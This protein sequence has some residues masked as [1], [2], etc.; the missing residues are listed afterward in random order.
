MQNYASLQETHEPD[1]EGGVLVHVAEPSRARWNHIEDL[2]S[3]FSR[4]YQYHQRHGLYCMLLQEVLELIQFVFIVV[5]T[6]YVFHGINYPVLFKDVP[7]PT[8]ATKV[9]LHDVVLPFGECVSNFSALTWIALIIAIIVWILKL[10]RGVYHFFHFWDIKQFYNTALKI[11]DGELDNL[12]WHEVQTKVRTVQIEQQMCIHKR[13]LSELDIYHRILRQQNYL[14]AM[15][16]K[17]L[18]PPRLKVPFLGEVVYWTSGL[19]LNIQLLFF[20]SPWSPFEHPWHLREE[21]K[22]PNLR[23]DLANQFGKHILWLALANL[24]FAP[25]IF[26]WQILYAFFSYAAIIRKEPSL[27]AVRRWSL[28]GRLYLRHFNELEHE[29]QARLT[30]AHRP[31]SKYLAA[32]TSPL[33]TIISENIGFYATSF[34]AVLV[35]LSIID[36]DVLTV[37]HVLTIMT[38]LTVA[39]AVL[40]SLAPDETTSSDLE[41]L[42]T[43]VVLHTHYLPTDW[44]G[45]A[46][47]ARVRKEFEQLFQYGFVSLLE[48]ILSPLLTPYILWRHIYPRAIEIVD[49]FRNFTVSVVGVGDVCSFAQMDV[50]KHGNPE[51]HEEEISVPD[52]Y[53]QCEDGKVE[54]SLVHFKCTNPS[55]KPPDSVQAFVKNVQNQSSMIASLSNQDPTRMDESLG[56]WRIGEPCSDGALGASVMLRRSAEYHTSRMWTNEGI[57]PISIRDMALNATYLHSIHSNRTENRV[58]NTAQETTPLLSNR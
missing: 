51:W 24:V 55:W 5:L 6:A 45:Q 39:V 49:F 44:V 13:E 21:Y 32:F 30:R 58:R 31:A 9:T 11:E 37:E 16:N 46:H 48:T 26:L 4:M 36:E 23:H 18:L 20:W 7:P 27:L 29:L 53:S 12:T 43:K 35:G 34:L 47:T 15:V 19:R 57:S 3:F 56:A 28:Y 17:R 52:Q 33:G 1:E 2:D 42:L 50:R 40:R 25:I 10:I 54:L 14:V 8:N 38:F 41:D 22:K